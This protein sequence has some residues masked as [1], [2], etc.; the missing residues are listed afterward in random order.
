VAAPGLWKE[1]I[2]RRGSKKGKSNS[3]A[4]SRTIGLKLKKKGKNYVRKGATNSAI[5]NGSSQTQGRKEKQAVDRL[6]G[7]KTVVSHSRS[8]GENEP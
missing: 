5:K 3:K 2:V 1:K 7:K 6:R 8:L 4:A